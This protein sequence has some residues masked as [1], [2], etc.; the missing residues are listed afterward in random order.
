LRENACINPNGLHWSCVSLSPLTSKSGNTRPMPNGTHGRWPQFAYSRSLR[1][2][3]QNGSLQGTY[4]IKWIQ[5]SLQQ[6]ISGPIGKPMLS[7][8][9]ICIIKFMTTPQLGSLGPATGG[10]LCETQWQ[11]WKKIKSLETQLKSLEAALK[12]LKAKH[13]ALRMDQTKE[14]QNN[15]KGKPMVGTR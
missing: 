11:S 14:K 3:T 6:S 2:S 12:S 5:S 4:K 13:D 15:W 9:N 10:Q 7:W 8:K 1:S